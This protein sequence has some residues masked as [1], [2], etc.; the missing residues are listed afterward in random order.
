MVNNIKSGRD[1]TDDV[2]KSLVTN[3]WISALSAVSDSLSV[4]LSIAKD[5][6]IDL[7]VMAC[8]QDSGLDHG[9]V[10]VLDHFDWDDKI[11]KLHKHR[12]CSLSI[13]A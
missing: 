5:R 3:L 11:I 4:E 7:N 2:V 8:V 13:A 6:D 1:G 10:P 9:I 12:C